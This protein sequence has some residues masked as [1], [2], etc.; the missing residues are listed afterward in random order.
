MDMVVWASYFSGSKGIVGSAVRR[1]ACAAFACQVSPE[2]KEISLPDSMYQSLSESSVI[3]QLCSESSSIHLVQF[4][5]YVSAFFIVH[6]W[7]WFL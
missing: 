5:V 4:E 3:R 1:S 6:A 7:A 2:C